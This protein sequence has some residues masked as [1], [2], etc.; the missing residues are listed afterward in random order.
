MVHYI[1]LY[2]SPTGRV[3]RLTWW[4]HGILVRVVTFVV[5][6][7]I[8]V[9]IVQ[10]PSTRGADAQPAESGMYLVA[11]LVLLVSLWSQYALTIKRFHDQNRSAWWALWLLIPG[12]GPLIG[13]VL[14]GCLPGTSETNRYGT[15]PV[16]H[17]YR[18]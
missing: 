12:F 18:Q 6:I 7:A 2:F 4:M 5:L 13:V 17:A 1:N 10:Q 16:T 11:L 14:A 3:S 8:S 15:V 9:S